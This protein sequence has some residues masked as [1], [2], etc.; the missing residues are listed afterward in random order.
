MSSFLG[1]EGFKE[2]LVLHGMKGHVVV[3]I[4]MGLESASGPPFLKCVPPGSTT[5]ESHEMVVKV[6]FPRAT[7]GYS[8]MRY[9]F[10][11]G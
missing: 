2:E 5:P 4:L 7:L 9:A 3:I 11:S 6:Q 8:L 1:R 10:S